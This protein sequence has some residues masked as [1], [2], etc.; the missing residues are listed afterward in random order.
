M[1]SLVLVLAG[2]TLSTN[3]LSKVTIEKDKV[4]IKD[5]NSKGFYPPGQAKK[6]QL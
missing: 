1:K 4:T 2:C 3:T 5:S 6:G